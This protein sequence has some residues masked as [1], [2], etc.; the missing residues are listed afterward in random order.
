MTHVSFNFPMLTIVFAL[1]CAAATS[2]IHSKRVSR[3]VSLVLLAVVAAMTIC[4]LR[5]VLAVGGTVTYK[6]GKASAPWGNELRFGPMELGMSLFFTLVMLLTVFAGRKYYDRDISDHKA[7]LYYVMVDLTQ[8][9]MLAL[10]YTNDVFT[11]FVF[12]EICTIA[13]AG[14]LMSKRIG[15]TTLA[16]VRYLIF[17]LVGSGL[18]LIGVVLLYGVTGHLLMPFIRPAVEQLWAA[19]TYRIP[20][21]VVIALVSMGLAVK[22][23]LWPFHL[24]MPDTYSYTTPASSGVLS[25]LISKIYI[26]LLIKFIYQVI[27]PEVYY[28]SGVG[29]ILFLLG[30]AG[31]F[32]GSVSAI[33]ENDIRR[34]LAFSSAA[35]IGYIYMGIGLSPALG[36][37]AALFH[38]LAHAL[39]KPLLFLSAA[40]LAE[41]GGG[42]TFADLQNTA[43]RVPLAGFGF[44]VGSL[45]MVGIPLFMG[46]I[47]K[48]Q[49]ASA[50]VGS[51]WRMLPALI[52][53]AVSTILNT[54]YFLRTVL[55]IYSPHPVAPEHGPAREAG[56]PPMLP[57]P[58]ERIAPDR[59]F[60][61]SAVVFIAGNVALG[62]CAQP[63][64]TL[65]QQGLALLGGAA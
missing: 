56:L 2:A 47:A 40:D 41:A 37:A 5:D 6:M 19:G 9:A 35:Q 16:S 59:C 53:L 60:V 43:Y 39:T 29:N 49:L 48:V 11:A 22:S 45:S 25:G 57:D 65:L 18:F 1:M 30:L 55:R 17:S 13:S 27:G 42:V 31:M 28:A 10:A 4:T 44:L 33:R 12:V 46:F 32:F 23:G 64:I 38:I 61:V 50:A 63:L 3:T 21:I 62:V 15:R 20:L 14:L 54:M 58:V 34:M 36:V 8:A 51:G 52:M 26:L 24:W 7:N